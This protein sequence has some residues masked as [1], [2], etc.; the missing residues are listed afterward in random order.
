M[1][2]PE[3]CR[4]QTADDILAGHA[5]AVHYTPPKDSRIRAT[6]PAGGYAIEFPTIKNWGTVRWSLIYATVI[7]SAFSLAILNNFA[8]FPLVFALA[9][10]GLLAGPSSRIEA[11]AEKLCWRG[12]WIVFSNSAVF[13]K[14]E[15]ADVV[16][17]EARLSR[18]HGR[19]C[20]HI[21]LLL[22]SGQKVILAK[23]LPDREHALWLAQLMKQG[24]GLPSPSAASRCL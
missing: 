16:V 14:H 8:F 2:E 20:Y 6:L 7:G 12:N 19:L 3:R 5:L 23:A 24:M 21:R 15:I 10:L 4:P 22:H 1:A 9:V 13:Q 18:S 11:D 17:A